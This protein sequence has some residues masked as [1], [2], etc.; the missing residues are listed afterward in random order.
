LH[1]SY[2]SLWK[3]PLA[4]V[5]CGECDN[6]PTKPCSE[7]RCKSISSNCIYSEVDGVGSCG[8]KQLREGDFNFRIE[9]IYGLKND[10]DP[11]M[12]ISRMDELDNYVSRKLVLTEEIFNEWTG[13]EVEDVE[14]YTKLLIDAKADIP[15]N[16]KISEVAY[17]DFNRIG[18]TYD[19]FSER[20]P[21]LIDAKSII[22]Q[23]EDAIINQKIASPLQMLN[24][25]DNMDEQLDESIAKLEALELTDEQMKQYND[26]IKNLGSGLGFEYEG[27]AD[28][29]QQS[30]ENF[31]TSL[32]P[33]LE[34]Y[35]ELNQELFIAME[36]KKAY[37]FVQ[38][39]DVNENFKERFFLTYTLMDDNRKPILVSSDPADNSSVDAGFKLR[40]GI[41]EPVECKYD[42]S[43]KGYEKMDSMDCDNNAKYGLYYCEDNINV[44][45]GEIFIRCKDQPVNIEEYKLKIVE[46]LQNNLSGSNVVSSASSV[47]DFLGMELFS[48][49]LFISSPDYIR[50]EK[51]VY[52]NLNQLR[53]ELEFPR[54]KICKVTADDKSFDEISG[55]F[56]CGWF[57]GSYRCSDKLDVIGETD[58]RILCRNDIIEK[59][60]EALFKLKYN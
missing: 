34:D 33:F 38:C 52:F 49:R 20:I 46:S 58:Y 45:S 17:T 12:V 59:R 16:C 35:N 32:E 7:Y 60:N 23:K 47:K 9:G 54:S 25:G 41:N 3:P 40:L 1:S 6:N 18:H 24:L 29:L 36:S 51:T 2:C 42:F 15:M 14:P 28:A 37:Y 57:E 50:D 31:D 55:E 8:Y 5:R 22:Q 44:S 48:D 21:V 4:D 30:R 53:L 39:A 19:F 11:R 43:D 26:V 13:Y 27:M 10:S 56:S